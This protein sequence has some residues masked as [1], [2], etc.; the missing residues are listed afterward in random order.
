MIDESS[1]RGARVIAVGGGKGGVGKSVVASNLAVG[2]AEMGARVTL[3]DADLGAANQ[4]TL[5]GIDRVASGITDLLEHRITD[6]NQATCGTQVP[7]LRLVVGSGAVPNAANINHGQKLRLLRQIRQLDADVVVVDVGAGT[8]HNVID[9]FDSGDARVVVVTP[10][11]TSIQNAYAFLKAAVLRLFRREAGSA[12]AVRMLEAAMTSRETERIDEI[13]GRLDVT[14]P[15]LGARLRQAVR[16]FDARLVGN[17]IA[18]EQDKGVFL[19]VGRMIRDFLGVPLP[20]AGFLGA[21]RELYASVNRRTPFLCTGAAH[22]D[23]AKTLRAIAESLLR[24]L[25]DYPLS[26]KGTKNHAIAHD[27]DGMLRRHPRVTVNWSAALEKGGRL[28]SVRVLDVSVGGVGISTRQHLADGE[29]WN[30]TLDEPEL[31]VTVATIVRNVIE[32]SAR[33][34][35]AFETEDDAPQKIV[36]AAQAARK[37]S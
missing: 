11:L 28:T 18:E 14:A 16:H 23:N 8:S 32:D 21:S 5:F 36:A 9:F 29:R 19:G 37:V 15:E 2:L 12:D 7:N 13:L 6:L 34:G 4:H 1:E 20:I 3:V 30:L 10:Q 33:V 24:D 31:K 25:P 27:L 35:L 17:Q 26:E 22:D